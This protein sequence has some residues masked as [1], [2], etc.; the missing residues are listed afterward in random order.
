MRRQIEVEDDPDVKNK[1]MD[2][3]TLGPD[4]PLS[5]SI[6][7]QPVQPMGSA[8]MKELKEVGPAS[9][10]AGSGPNALGPVQFG[11]VLSLNEN[12]WSVWT[13]Q[14]EVQR[15]KRRVTPWDTVEPASGSP[16][17]RSDTIFHVGTVVSPDPPCSAQDRM[18]RW[19]DSSGA[20]WSQPIRMP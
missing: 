8:A 3:E 2:T 4:S 1:D 19:K 17:P 15:P 20:P 11:R 16:Q 18:Q 5:F 13:K 7:R 12:N 14:N 6:G 9:G 10:F